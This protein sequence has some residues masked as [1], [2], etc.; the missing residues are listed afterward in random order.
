MTLQMPQKKRPGVAE[1]LPLM[2]AAA[3]AVFGAAQEG[4]TLGSVAG[5]AMNG[6]GGGSAAGSLLNIGRQQAQVQQT[7][8]GQLA[9]MAREQAKRSQD[10]LGTLQQAEAALPQLPE[11]LRQAYA[12]PIIKARMLAQRER[13]IA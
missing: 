7:G 6:F 3:G 4:A 13:G 5:S 1:S 11:E 10:T 9:A 12:E 2:G 8:G